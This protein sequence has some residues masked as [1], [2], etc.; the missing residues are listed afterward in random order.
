MCANVAPVCL[1]RFGKAIQSVGS[2]KLRIIADKV[3]TTRRKYPGFN[4]SFRGVDEGGERAGR[5]AFPVNI[6]CDGCGFT[7]ARPSWL[8][9]SPI[10]SLPKLRTASRESRPLEP[11]SGDDRDPIAPRGIIYHILKYGYRP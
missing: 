4:A 7:V 9:R 11:I 5:R 10:H 2:G 1:R 8:R 6:R 3:D